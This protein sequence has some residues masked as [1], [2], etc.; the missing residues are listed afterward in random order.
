MF[1]DVVVLFSS[2]SVTCFL[3]LSLSPR[4]LLYYIWQ[5]S[6]HVMACRNMCVRMEGTSNHC[7]PSPYQSGYA[8]C[9]KCTVYI[10]S[11]ERRC[12]CCHIKLRRRARG[13]ARTKTWIP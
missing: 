11:E 1:V 6:E 13:S 9:Q 12:P 8:Y 10:K 4:C 3:L 2:P 5:I 7:F